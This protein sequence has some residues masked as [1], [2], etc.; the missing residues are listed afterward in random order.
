MCPGCSAMVYR[1]RFARAHQACPECGRHSPLTACSGSTFDVIAANP[2]FSL[3]W[4][5]WAN[6]PRHRRCR[7]AVVG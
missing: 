6:D 4:K 5:P 1:K 7:P 3:K 2:P